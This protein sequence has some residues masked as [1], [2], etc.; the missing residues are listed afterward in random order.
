MT[1]LVAAALEYKPDLILEL[2][3]NKG[4]STCAFTEA[5]NQLGPG[6]CRV[7]SLCDSHSWE[8]NRPAAV[9]AVVPGD[10]FKPL[11]TYSGNILDFDHESLLAG[12]NRVLVFWDAH[13]FDVAECVL[14]RILPLLAQREHLVIMHDISDARYAAPES[15]E[16]GENP[17]W[18]GR[19]VPGARIRL[20][21]ID[22]AVE[23]AVAI[24]DF[25]NRNKLELHSADESI[26]T[27]LVA[28]HYK[29]REIQEILGSEA[30]SPQAHW[31]YFSLNDH[32]GPYTFPKVRRRSGL[33]HWLGSEGWQHQI[34]QRLRMA[35][36]RVRPT[37]H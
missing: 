14:G 5:A 25:A 18:R 21:N 33:A 11:R 20:G 26:Q 2:G 8:L 15:A 3:R 13:G 12:A 32:P 37:R 1:E 6:R 16:Y 22:S 29:L 34:V 36:A 27:D 24:V 35:A 17:L 19:A 23:Q 28:N 9:A 4:N 31:L 10:W 30:F 7:I